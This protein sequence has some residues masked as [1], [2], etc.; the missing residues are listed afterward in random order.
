MAVQAKNPSTNPTAGAVKTPAPDVVS[1]PRNPSGSGAYGQNQ[2]N[3]PSSVNPGKRVVSP[4]AAN[5]ESTADDDGALAQVIASGAESRDEVLNKQTRAIGAKNV[6]TTRGMHDPNKAD[7]KVPGG[8][9]HEGDPQGL[10]KAMG[11]E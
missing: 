11:F 1:T 9:G 8:P 5:L 4:L 2:F 3:Q 10:K 6:G 7:E